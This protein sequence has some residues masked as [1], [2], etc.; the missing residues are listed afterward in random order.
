VPRL[1]SALDIVNPFP[2]AATYQRFFNYVRSN[3]GKE[4]RRLWNLVQQK[5]PDAPLS[6]LYLPPVFFEDL[7]HQRLHP[8]SGVH[9]VWGHP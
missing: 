6:L 4:N 7:L 3:S 9:D 5:L 8:D 2:K 1:G